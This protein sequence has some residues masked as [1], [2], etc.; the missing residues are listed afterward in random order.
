[1]STLSPPAEKQPMVRR[2]DVSVKMDAEVV[3]E[4]RIAAA[5]RGLS[6]AEYISETMR[7]AA[8]RDI[9]DGYAR[10][11]EGLKPKGKGPKS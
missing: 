4:C 6:I 10:R 11:S 7:V 2:N 3:E 5:F 8:R 1:M 9:D